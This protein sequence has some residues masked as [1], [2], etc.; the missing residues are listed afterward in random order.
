MQRPLPF[1]EP[2][3]ALQLAFDRP[4]PQEH[5]WPPDRDFP[6]D[7]WSLLGQRVLAE[8]W[9]RLTAERATLVSAAPV[10]PAPHRPETAA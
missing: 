5:T 4:V 1:I 2:T 10:V 9:R 3:A 8:A 7:P 6:P